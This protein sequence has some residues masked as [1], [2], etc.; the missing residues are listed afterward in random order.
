MG[1]NFLISS[2]DYRVNNKKTIEELNQLL[3]EKVDDQLY[4]Q[5]KIGVF[6][7]GGIDSSL[8]AALAKEVKGEDI[9]CITCGFEDKYVKKDFDE[10]NYAKNFTS[11]LGIKHIIKNV[12]K[13][14]L[15]EVFP[16]LPTI[17]SEPFADISQIGSY[18]ISKKARENDIVVALGGDGADELFGGYDRY[19]NGPKLLKFNKYIIKNIA[20]F[21]IDSVYN[22]V[23]TQD[24]ISKFLNI[25][26]LKY[27]I[28]KYKNNFYD[29][30]NIFN[31]YEKILQNGINQNY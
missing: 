19:I 23:N 17:Y 24:I 26:K 21:L 8:V 9:T 7:S 25:D 1:Y 11:S 22:S 16:K 29:C 28:E 20:K 30:D 13:N 10:S 12:S 27:K 31:L 5:R 18:L 6:L 4:S 14:D 2:E 3:L 15:L